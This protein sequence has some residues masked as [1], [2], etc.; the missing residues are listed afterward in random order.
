MKTP[1]PQLFVTLWQTPY[2]FMFEV[3][4]LPRVYDEAP[5]V[6]PETSKTINKA[7]KKFLFIFLVELL[8]K[9]VNL[10]LLLLYSFNKN[11]N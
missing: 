4:L 2:S 5:R 1:A 6:N 8:L 7:R 3:E 9:L 10:L 11:S